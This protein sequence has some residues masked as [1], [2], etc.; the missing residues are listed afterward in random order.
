[1]LSGLSP[2]ASRRGS[3]RGRSIAQVSRSECSP[4]TPST[5]PRSPFRREIVEGI[6]VTARLHT[7]LQSAAPRGSST[8]IEGVVI[9]VEPSGRNRKARV[10]WGPPVSTESDLSLRSLTAVG[11]EPRQ[12]EQ[13]PQVEEQSSDTDVS[14]SEDS[15][16]EVENVDETVVVAGGSIWNILPSL[17]IDARGQRH[18][19]ACRTSILHPPG[20]VEK[21]PLDYFLRMW[22][23]SAFPIWIN[24]TNI[25]LLQRRN[26]LQGESERKHYRPLLFNELMRFLAT[27]LFMSIYRLPRAEFWA[28]G[29][30]VFDA[31]H[32]KTKSGIS[33]N[34]FQALITSLRFIEP[35]LGRTADEYEQVD[36]LLDQF[37]S[38]RAGIS[39]ELGDELCIDELFSSWLGEKMPHVTKNPHKPKGV[40]GEFIALSDI[41]SG[42]MVALEYCKGKENN[43]RLGGGIQY[44]AAVTLRL[45]RLARVPGTCRRIVGDSR[46]SSVKCAELALENGF[47]Y[48]GVIKTATKGFPKRFLHDHSIYSFRGETK[49]LKNTGNILAFGWFDCSLNFTNPKRVKSFVSTCGTTLP[50]KPHRKFRQGIRNGVFQH[51]TF[52]VPRCITVEDY[53]NGCG[54][55]D[56]H[57]HL[58]QGELGLE[59]SWG[60]QDWQSR[61]A[62][63]LFGIF[64]TDSFLAFCFE[65]HPIPFRDFTKLVVNQ[66]FDLYQPPPKHPQRSEADTFTS[67]QLRNLAELEG[68]PNQKRCRSLGCTRSQTHR[69][70]LTR[71]YCSVCTTGVQNI[72]SL[73]DSRSGRFCFLNHRDE[74]SQKRSRT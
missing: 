4:S 40:G 36:A 32:L 10:R 49:V 1:M 11:E 30:G 70:M 38:V 2:A 47:D 35:V 25:Q 23:T 21:S 74:E 69:S 5:P 3:S 7:V 29:E 16:H 12:E 73:C 15:D 56:R 19:I 65:N 48:T 37:H 34:R 58:R 52:D 22:P 33:R 68:S 24:A 26:A 31:F 72:V 46:F 43:A 6:R 53:F 44:G 61:I 71:W 62:S 64:Q 14:E 63:T 8:L 66:I 59:M 20:G 54:S 55:V 39:I 57:N 67:C 50:G 28:R 42:I 9:L 41:S 45:A 60:T 51:W 13:E 18:P 27:L 17:S